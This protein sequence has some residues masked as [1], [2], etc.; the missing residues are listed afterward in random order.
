MKFCSLG[1]TNACAQVLARL[2]S[3][4]TAYSC[5]MERTSGNCNPAHGLLT[6]SGISEALSSQKGY[7][8]LIHLVEYMWKL[9]QTYKKIEYSFPIL[10]IF[11]S[12]PRV[13]TVRGISIT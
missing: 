1:E 7:F 12:S 10:F 5:C 9:Q 2:Y 6:K 8:Y 4:C 11:I 13:K 3:S